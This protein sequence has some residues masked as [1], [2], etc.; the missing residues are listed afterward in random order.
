MR[1][2]FSVSQRAKG[3]QRAFHQLQFRRIHTPFQPLKG[4][5]PD[6]LYKHLSEVSVIFK[7]IR[8]LDD[9]FL[10]ELTVRSVFEVAIAATSDNIVH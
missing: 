4:D 6:H 1:M 7:S 5:Q 8:A 10:D 3:T 2:S 9:S